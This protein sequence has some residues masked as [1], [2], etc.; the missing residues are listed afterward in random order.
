M[1]DGYRIFGSGKSGKMAKKYQH[2][3][4][5]PCLG[6]PSMRERTRRIL[7]TF[8]DITIYTILTCVNILIAFENTIR[9]SA[10]RIR[11]SVDALIVFLGVI[12]ANVSFLGLPYYLQKELLF[13]I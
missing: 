13:S 2:H 3:K 1:Q 7:H 5:S 6:T 8:S 9:I 12:I 11:M 10:D 4:F